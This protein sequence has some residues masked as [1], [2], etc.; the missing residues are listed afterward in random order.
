MRN[1]NKNLNIT[2]VG[3][4]FI[5][6]AIS[7]PWFNLNISNHD[8]VKSYTASFGVSLLMLVALYYQSLKSDILIQVNYVKLT[9]FLLFLF[10]SL[11]ILWGVNVDFAIGKWLLWLIALF[12]F[13]LSLNLSISH[14]N[15][16]KL[17]W[18]LVF[19][20]GIIAVIGLLQRFFNPF[21]KS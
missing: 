20:A 16:I 19:A 18:G 12:S 4:F 1:I 6:L 3:S 21:S 9:L 2:W 15:L 8:I 7:A 17:S 11:S 13:V 5:F 10:G 14:V